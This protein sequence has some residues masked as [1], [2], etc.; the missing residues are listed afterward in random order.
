MNVLYWNDNNDMISGNNDLPYIKINKYTLYE[1]YNDK[2]I[3][4]EKISNELFV[5][6]NKDNNIIVFKDNNL[7]PNKDNKLYKSIYKIIF[8]FI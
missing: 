6:D 5:N 3:I 4:K 8:K 1:N 7:L 2:K